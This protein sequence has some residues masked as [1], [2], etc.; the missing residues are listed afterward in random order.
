MVFLKKIY[1]KSTLKV[2]ILLL[3][4]CSYCAKYT[5]GIEGVCRKNITL[6]D[7]LV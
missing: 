1:A 7:F 3:L 5:D 4:G 2:N 6:I